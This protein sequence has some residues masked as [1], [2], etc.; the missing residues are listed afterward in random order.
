MLFMTLLLFYGTERKI[1]AI[2]FVFIIVYIHAHISVFSAG[3]SVLQV[4]FP[5]ISADL[6]INVVCCC[7]NK[8]QLGRVLI[9]VIEQKFVIL[10][11]T[12]K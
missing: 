12:V 9:I 6:P 3:S 2:E 8:M 1:I 11:L 7:L 4:C 10:D 5:V